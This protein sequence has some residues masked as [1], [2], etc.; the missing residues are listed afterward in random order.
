[1]S[2]NH[3]ENYIETYRLHYCLKI[4]LSEISKICEENNIKYFLIG[5]SLLGAIRHNG[6]IPWDD[7]LDIGMLRND[8]EKF[9]SICSEKLSNEFVLYNYRNNRDYPLPYSKILMKGTYFDEG[10]SVQG[11]EKLIFVDVFPIDIMPP[12]KLFQKIQKINLYYLA[13]ALK[14]KCKYGYTNHGKIVSR[15]IVYLISMMN[16]NQLVKMT[17]KVQRKSYKN[18]EKYINLNGSYSYGKE[19][20]PRDSL[21]N[22]LIYTE[23]SGMKVPIPC[24][25]D[26]ILSTTYGNYMELPPEEKRLFRHAKDSI[27]YGKYGDIDP[28][29]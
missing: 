22:E 19:L 24:N 18:F 16:K 9:L 17:D 28:N 15:L 20:F 6:F 8:Y 27:S 4:I 25:S 5:G 12:Q 2:I 13:Q 29:S 26:E 10:I 3:M 11:L 1:M 23:F 21:E 7:D 14:R